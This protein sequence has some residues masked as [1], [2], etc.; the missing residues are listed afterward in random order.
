M[1]NTAAAYLCTGHR[2]TLESHPSQ[3]LNASVSIPSGCATL[4][5]SVNLVDPF[6]SAAALH[7]DDLFER[8]GAPIFVLNL[9]KV[10]LSIVD[11][12]HQFFNL[13]S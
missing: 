5:Y 8:Y 2:T 6:Y 1:F 13:F 3:T 12:I 10:R 7:F 4:T 9:V 11:R